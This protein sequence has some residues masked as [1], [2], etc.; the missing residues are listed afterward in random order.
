MASNTE[1][2]RQVHAALQEEKQ[3]EREERQN[4]KVNERYKTILATLADLGG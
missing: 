4:A 1:V 3:R 2:A